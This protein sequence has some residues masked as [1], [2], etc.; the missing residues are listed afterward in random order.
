[1]TRDSNIPELKIPA[2]EGL[3][4]RMSPSALPL[5]QWRELNGLYPA[6]AGLLQRIPGKTQFTQ[7]AGNPAV[8]NL[9]Q[10]NDGS[11]NILVQT[12][13]SLQVFTLDEL[14]NR[15]YSPSLSY[16]TL[17]EEESMS[18]AVMVQMEANAV[19]GGS[20]QGY[21]SG[22]DSSAAAKTFYGRRLTNMLFN[23]SSTIV[24][25]TASTGGAGAASTAGTFVLAPG[26]YRIR[27]YCLFNNFGSAG[28]FIAGL[29]NNTDAR[30][31]YHNTT[32]GA[33]TEPILF[34]IVRGG[35]NDNANLVATVDTGFIVSTSN[36]TFQISQ[37]ADIT[38]TGRR[39][40]CCGSFDTLT[41]TN[42]N[43]AAAK[44]YYTYITILKTA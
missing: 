33:G 25:F 2:L 18:M 37:E 34:T 21:I 23:E 38:T 28:T 41:D 20:I 39:L 30:F 16:T 29:Y 42:V 14:R 17:T 32:G 8:W 36:K 15:T 19:K 10:T 3:N 7:L 40:D 22:T 35:A 12:P 1:M 26:T 44:F 24:T 27:G 31:E 6:E 43:S 13:T 9:H 4:E 5:G 11:G